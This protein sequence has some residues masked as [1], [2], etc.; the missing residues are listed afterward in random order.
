M[1]A[2][3]IKKRLEY[4]NNTYEELQSQYLA[5]IQSGTKSYLVEDRNKVNLDL[6]ALQKAIAYAEEQIEELEALL[7]GGSR[8]KI[9]SVLPRDW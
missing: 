2:A 3:T 5:L 8:R 1:T 9:V 6:M 7:N 4:W